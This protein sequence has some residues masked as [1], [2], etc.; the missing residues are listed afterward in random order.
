LFEAVQDRLNQLNKTDLVVQGGGADG[1]DIP[2]VT[3]QYRLG[4]EWTVTTKSWLRT[5]SQEFKVTRVSQDEVV[6]DSSTS[7]GYRQTSFYTQDGGLKR[8]EAIV[9]GPPK[10][11]FRPAS[12]KELYRTIIDPP[13]YQVPSGFLQ[14]GRKWTT[15]NNQSVTQAGSTKPLT[16]TVEGQVVAREKVTVG[17][18]TF[19]AFKILII[20]SPAGRQKSAINH[21][22]VPGLPVPIK[23]TI[24]SEWGS[25]N[26]E[27]HSFKPGS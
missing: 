22:I 15:V 4:D 23:T 9:P 11:V 21:W 7:D 1:K 16:V 10:G 8:L 6:V 2:Y 24:E 12:P 25:S 14:V 20:N 17:A 3:R 19:D 13:T 27:L 26:T 18:G 5:T